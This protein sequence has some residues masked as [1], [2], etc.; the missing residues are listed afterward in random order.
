MADAV[1]PSDDELMAYGATRVNLKKQLPQAA[2]RVEIVVMNPAGLGMHLFPI[3]QA[4][5]D[6]VTIV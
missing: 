3:E 6:A 1:H 4:L 5:Q 2:Q